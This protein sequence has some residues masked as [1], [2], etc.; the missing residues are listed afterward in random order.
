MH[1]V[2]RSQFRSFF[3]NGPRCEVTIISQHDIL[4]DNTIGANL[5]TTSDSGGAI[6]DGGRM[7]RQDL[8]PDIVFYFSARKSIDLSCV[9][10]SE[11][12]REILN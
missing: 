2:S 1:R 5:D 10:E 8:D 7:N 11:E 4:L 12:C 3:D 6:N 9:A